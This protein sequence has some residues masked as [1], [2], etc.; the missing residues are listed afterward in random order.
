MIE[1]ARLQLGG[2]SCRMRLLWD[3]APELC[4][5]FVERLPLTSF[6]THA[7]FAGDELFFMVP[8][9]ARAENL[10]SAVTPG[11]VGYYPDRETVCIFYGEIVPFGQVGVFARV[12]EGNDVLSELGPRIW[13]GPALPIGVVPED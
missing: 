8:F 12:V 4:R 7:K 11:D 9:L 13:R 1:H 10:V 2:Q 5:R 3:L 6:V